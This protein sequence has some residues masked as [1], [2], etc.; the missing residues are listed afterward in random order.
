MTMSVTTAL[1]EAARTNDVAA[2]RQAIAD[3]IDINAR[4][5]DGFTPLHCAAAE[6]SLDV[7]LILLEAGAD[8]EASDRDGNTPLCTAAFDA[9]SHGMITLLRG[10][11]ADPYH[12]NRDGKTPADIA[13]ATASREVIQFFANLPVPETTND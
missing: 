10:R 7:A 13:R 4:D 12:R 6:Y 11:G 2:A 8:I 3:G 5:H 1:H 9:T